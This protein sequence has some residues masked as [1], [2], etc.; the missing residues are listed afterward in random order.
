M[1]TSFLK[2]V[3]RVLVKTGVN[4]VTFGM[5]GDLLDNIWQEWSRSTDADQRRRELAVLTRMSQQEV[6]R[7]AAAVVAAEAGEQPAEMQRALA[8][9]LTHVPAQVRASLLESSN[10]DSVAEDLDLCL[11]HDPNLGTAWQHQYQ[12][13]MEKALR[14]AAAAQ[15][16]ALDAGLLEL[17]PAAARLPADMRRQAATLLGNDAPAMAAAAEALASSADPR[18]WETLASLDVH[19]PEAVEQHTA[20]AIDR[21][22]AS[23]DITII[24][25][26]AAE[27]MIETL[28][29]RR[30]D[31]AVHTLR[32]ALG[33]ASP[34]V[35]SAALD[36]LDQ[37]GVGPA[38]DDE[39]RLRALAA[40]HWDELREL[41][42]G[43]IVPLLARQLADLDWYRRQK[44]AEAL[45]KLGD[46]CAVEPLI[47][48]LADE[49]EHV[50]GHA[51]EALA[52][53]GD[54]CAVPAL[55][56][57]LQ[58]PD[59]WV[60]K[61]TA[62]AL[63]KL[64]DTRSLPSLSACLDDLNVEVRLAA[65]HAIVDIGGAESV[66]LLTRA[67]HDTD[68]DVRQAASLGLSNDRHSR[69]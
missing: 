45:G 43:N 1:M 36:A 49:S 27:K 2:S 33:H 48:A 6:S 64:G 18:G 24:S 58:D 7:Q 63:G 25:A 65:V 17:L 28:R 44:A 37:R 60:R 22:L 56:G 59:D 32:V 47:S 46:R 55:L 40:E 4:A 30:G 11:I 57:N 34:E 69:L 42:P 9:F 41:G 19:W 10:T 21:L 5:G 38:S 23:A 52:A 8:S 53:L 3:A 61:W 62:D 26:R 68:A 13:M 35:R 16:S 66:P 29:Q 15:Q 12:E 50:R 14:D 54:R 67:Q 51:A 31:K 20:E 39:R